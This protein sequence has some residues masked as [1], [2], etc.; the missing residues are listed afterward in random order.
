MKKQFLGMILTAMIAV[1]VSACGAAGNGGSPS[2][3]IPE[4][5][6][7]DI[8]E[9]EVKELLT[10]A[11]GVYHLGE[12][13]VFAIGQIEVPFDDIMKKNILYYDEI[14]NYDEVIPTIFTKN[15]IQ[16]VEHSEYGLAPIILKRGGKVYRASNMVDSTVTIF[17]NTIRSV[18]L[19]EQSGNRY[20]FEVTHI[21][22]PRW[23][24]HATA[25]T[26]PDM[27]TQLV[28]VREG[29][30]LLVDELFY[31][32]DNSEQTKNR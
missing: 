32:L 21:A 18:T 6:P 9:E 4:P 25:D 30:Q 1:S 7:Q 31:P 23:F 14:T 16:I 12:G 15:G 28:V 8:S 24:D 5:M 10:K 26:A 2:G 19:L 29:D 22:E 27:I 17:F 3:T 13:T 11:E 20:S